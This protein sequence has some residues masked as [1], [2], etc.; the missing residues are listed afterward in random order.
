MYVTLSIVF[1]ICAFYII[2]A[3]LL[4][5]GART[6]NIMSNILHYLHHFNAG[7]PWL[8]HTLAGTHR[9][10]HGL[11]GHQCCGWSDILSVGEDRWYHHWASH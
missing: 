6:V 2:I 10:L 4:I 5:L 7:P 8:P 9:H 1:I 11:S 3:S